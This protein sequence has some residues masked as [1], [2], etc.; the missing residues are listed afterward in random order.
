MPTER[1]T[2]NT[3]MRETITPSI[4]DLDTTGIEETILFQK[5]DQAVQHV[6]ETLLDMNTNIVDQVRA[7]MN[8]QDAFSMSHLM[9]LYIDSPK[10]I[11]K[12]DYKVGTV[13]QRLNS[14]TITSLLFVCKFGK[15]KMKEM[16]CL[17]SDEHWLAF[18][19]KD[20]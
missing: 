13:K 10:S 4:Q 6:L 16:N 9:D 11:Q 19:N 8:F 14:W 15:S 2:P 1:T 17:L 20:F 5:Q 7:W 12:P 3:P 18:T